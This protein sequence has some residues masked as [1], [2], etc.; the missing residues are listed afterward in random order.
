MKNLIKSE[1][2]ML[3]L[4]SLALLTQIACPIHWAWYF[5]IFFLPDLGM[6]GYLFGAKVGAICYNLF[7]HKGIMLGLAVAGFL[8]GF[9]MLLIVGVLFYAHAAFDR[10]MGYGLKHFAGFKQT[11]LGSL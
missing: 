4:G 11:H 1:E 9:Q 6:L 8:L 3:T 7:H 2:L 5:L 10:I